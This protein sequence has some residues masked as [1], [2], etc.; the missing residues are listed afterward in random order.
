MPYKDKTKAL[1]YIQRRRKSRRFRKKMNAQNLERWRQR[2]GYYSRQ[3]AKRLVQEV[4]QRMCRNL[5]AIGMSTAEIVRTTG[6][7]LYT[8]RKHLKS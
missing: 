8:V 5:Q 3:K 7:S 2:T 1:A 4:R 6:L